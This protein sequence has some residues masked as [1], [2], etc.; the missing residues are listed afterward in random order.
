MEEYKPE[1]IVVGAIARCEK[2]VEPVVKTLESMGIEVKVLTSAHL[3]E[4]VPDMIPMIAR[5]N[6]PEAILISP[7]GNEVS[8]AANK[9]KSVHAVIAQD[10]FVARRSRERLG[11]N[12]L[13]LPVELLD[14]QQISE[15]I[16]SW[17]STPYRPASHNKKDEL[18]RVEQSTQE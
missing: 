18:K 1:C 4:L 12:V 11:C 16:A 7:T 6:L 17:C 5:S 15:T 10:A 2:F 9:F 13:C 8:I 3:D 14:T